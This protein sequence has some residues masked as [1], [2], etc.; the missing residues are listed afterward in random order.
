MRHRGHTP[1]RDRKRVADLRSIAIDKP[2]EQQQADGVGS[3][4]CRVD[5]AELLVCPAQ[6][7]VEKLFDQSED[8]TIDVINGRREEKQCADAPSHTAHAV[9]TV[10]SAC[11]TRPAGN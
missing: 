6:L 2:S 11:Q 4:K 3:L 7:A 8:L 5:Q 1:Q 10:S 9:A